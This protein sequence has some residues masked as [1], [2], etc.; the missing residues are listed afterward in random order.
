[1]NISNSLISKKIPKLA[2]TQVLKLQT[3]LASSSS[4]PWLTFHWL[5]K[6]NDREFDLLL[7]FVLPELFALLTLTMTLWQRR[8][9]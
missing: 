6:L 8:Q 1:M 4:S 5:N 3:K 2:N 7:L 9:Q